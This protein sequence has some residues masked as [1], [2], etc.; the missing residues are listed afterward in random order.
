[1]PR[2]LI[3]LRLISLFIFFSSA[4]R[5][6]YTAE[7]YFEHLTI[8]DGLSSNNIKCIL[9][10]RRGFIWIGTTAGLNRYD[11]YQFKH[12]MS[13]P[14]D[15][16]SLPNS[17]INSMVEDDSGDIW[18]ATGNG[19]GRY[20]P[21][22]ETFTRYYS[23]ADD[24]Q[25]L[26]YNRTICVYKDR[27]GTLWIGT[28]NGLNRYNSKEDNFSRYHFKTQRDSLYS[29]QVNRTI[30]AISEDQDGN[31]L[32]GT[33]CEL[34]RFDPISETAKAVPNNFAGITDIGCWSLI[35]Q[36]YPGS[37]NTYL[38]AL[39]DRLL[40]V[41][42]TETG[43]A[44][45][46]QLTPDSLRI[47]LSG[48]DLIYK[49]RKDVLWL[50]SSN[51]L[52][53]YHKS[54]GQWT[55]H[56]HNSTIPHSISNDEITVILED[57]QGN[58]WLGTSGG[59]VNKLAIW[60]KRFK[61]YTY[62]SEDMHGFPKSEVSNIS[63]DDSGN[64]W[65]ATNGSGYTKLNRQTGECVR[66]RHIEPR[67]EPESPDL[68]D[69]SP[70]VSVLIDNLGYVWTSNRALNRLD[71]KTED[72]KVYDYNYR[73]PQ[74]HSDSFT[75]VLY[76]DKDGSL[77]IGTYDC[78]L[79][80]FNRNTE[81]FKHYKPDPR[82]STSLS[83]PGVFSIFRDQAEKL[84]IGTGNGLCKVTADAQAR[85]KFIRYLYRKENRPDIGRPYIIIHDIF[86]DTSGRFWLGTT[87][88]LFQFNRES[89]EHTVYTIADGLPHNT[90]DAILE[91]NSGFLWLRGR[92]GLVK[93]D[94]EAI[95]FR[96]Y[97]EKDGLADY[98]TIRAG[99]Q[100][101]CKGKDG[102]FYYGGTGAL[103]VYH[104][105]SLWDNPDPPILVLTDFKIDNQS[106]E[107][108][109]DSPLKKSIFTTDSIRLTF[110]QKN[111][112]FEFAAIDYTSPDKNQHAYKMEGVDKDWVYCGGNRLAN[113][114]NLDPGKYIF[115]I[116]G[117]NNDGLWN[118][119]AAF[120]YIIISPPWY[121]T[122]GAYG[123]Y[124]LLGLAII[125]FT[126][127]TQLRRIRLKNDLKMRTFESEKLKEVDSLKSR[128]FA[129][130]SH[131][132]RTPIT[133]I[134][135]P[136]E[137][138]LPRIQQS[139]IKQ[140]LT[141]MQ[142]NA[143]RLLRL[144]N[145]L[146]DLSRL[147]AGRLK[148]QTRRQDIVPLVNRFVQS[149]ESQAKLK[150]IELTFRSH[151]KTIWMYIDQ[152]KL[153]NIVYNLVSNALK[154]TS[155]GGK[156]TVSLRECES[157]DKFANGYAEIVVQDSG[158][159]IPPDQIDKVF[160]RFYQADASI[161]REH[162]GSGIGLALTKE[163]VDLFKGDISVA[164]ELGVGTSFTILLPLG[165]DHLSEDE[166]VKVDVE[167]TKPREKESAPEPTL[168]S[169]EVALQPPKNRQL[170]KPKGAPILLIVE[171][172]SDLRTYMRDIL[173]SNYSIK[174]AADGEKGFE[175]ALRIIPDLII[176]DVM[177][178]VMD[179]IKMCEKLK[180]DQKTSH[181]PV[182]LLT[183][184]A[185][186]ESK[187]E[188]LETGADDYIVKPFE[189]KELL[190]RVRNLFENRRKLRER[191][192]KDIIAVSYTH[193][194]LPTN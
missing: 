132:F 145:Q 90:I 76:E 48:R 22:T 10:D 143:R 176:S 20:H 172:N 50:G 155:A 64:I 73:N 134:L 75:F 29:D 67:F 40:N 3:K 148:L 152:G 137:K 133:L 193:L 41:S 60:R 92:G 56:R 178:P 150:Q 25:T 136:L 181:I 12:Y 99:Y 179:G 111:I 175:Q 80:H 38:I 194:T 82:D 142:R 55:H 5:F 151:E 35:R 147:E 96:T 84:W 93:F 7:L 51:G 112:S 121:A 54:T 44:D 173:Q 16:T 37:S 95:T 138:M 39:S 180:T 30:S 104:P 31:L 191:F 17:F 61:H 182:I 4:S 18:L 174:E 141:L 15:S 9:Q 120:V 184:R 129:N 103:A 126:W 188:G 27:S 169:E 156:M 167:K 154:Y 117:C 85:I 14:A 139:D 77:W 160:D 161:T 34:L 70:V 1:M 130:I 83:S 159:G 49:D 116:K 81:T 100:A 63:Q 32:I 146:L 128:F 8:K 109:G 52:Y 102:E 125:A 185:G 46:S 23:I 2:V 68:Y 62:N 11:G 6:L 94:P 89:G 113:Y 19:L 72:V 57:R 98:I 13:D 158:V 192:T 177:M 78:G 24:P 79:E 43:F 135:G 97:D 127:R 144:I 171:D 122:F 71:R 110:K 47:V 21:E 36:I 42:M 163:L 65:L 33:S 108:G 131:E 88:G 123:L 87:S 164:S 118:E 119:E 153:E 115:R 170:Q 106:V 86:E 157:T 91:D 105:D 187:L 69:F 74:S 107:T 140:D 45:V 28:H 149:F 58:L 183:A 166:I 66:Y 186:L 189:T 59:G 124:A 165:R 190:V 162:E 168:E 114:T 101:F 26:S 53:H